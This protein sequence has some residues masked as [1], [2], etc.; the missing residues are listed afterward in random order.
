MLVE[1]RLNFQP[2]LIYYQTSFIYQLIA[3][4]ARTPSITQEILSNNVERKHRSG[5]QK[6]CLFFQQPNQDF[7]LFLTFRYLEILWSSQQ[8]K[9]ITFPRPHMLKQSLKHRMAAKSF[10][11]SSKACSSLSLSLFITIMK[12]GLAK[13]D[14]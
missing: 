2:F 9:T 5:V 14:Q 8:R 13:Q 11:T 4:R 12:A 7:V 3:A 6:I 10:E 1:L